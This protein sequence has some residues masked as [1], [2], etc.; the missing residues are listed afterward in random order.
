MVVFIKL[1]HGNITAVLRHIECF[2]EQPAFAVVIL[3]QQGVGIP[4]AGGVGQR[5]VRFFTQ[6]GQRVAAFPLG[7]AAHRN[8]IDFFLAAQLFDQTFGRH[9]QGTVDLVHE[10]SFLMI[11]R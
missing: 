5:G 3:I 1:R 11:S 10:F 9:M 7:G 8:G 6:S 2:A 4:G